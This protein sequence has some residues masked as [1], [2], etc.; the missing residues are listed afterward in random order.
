MSVWKVNVWKACRANVYKQA[1][2]HRGMNAPGL[3]VREI[4]TRL[5][6]SQG[7]MSTLTGS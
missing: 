5:Y 7:G 1:L 4:Y 3:L 6:P 2:D